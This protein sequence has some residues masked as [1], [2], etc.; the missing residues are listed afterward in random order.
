MPNWEFAQL[1]SSGDN[2]GNRLSFTH[3][4][5]DGVTGRFRCDLTK[6]NC[7]E[8]VLLQGG[9]WP[10]LRQLGDEGWDMFGSNGPTWQEIWFK[11]VQKEG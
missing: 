10:A 7:E 11:R 1:F 6:S 9:W 5:D 2:R 4:Q 3:P 8:I